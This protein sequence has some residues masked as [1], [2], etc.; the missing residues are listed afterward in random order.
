MVAFY[1]PRGPR[2]LD[3]DGARM[4]EVLKEYWHI[5]TAA[6]LS[7]GWLVRLEARSL[8]NEREIRRLWAQ[9]KEDIALAQR[10][11]DAQTR[12][13]DEIRQDIKRLLSRSND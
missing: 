12:I 10:A 1:N 5:L 9:R 2:C 3:R 8:S 13:L 4:M 11:Q 6:V 7:V